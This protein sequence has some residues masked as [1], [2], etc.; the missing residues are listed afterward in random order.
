MMTEAHR[1]IP[2]S[3]AK[4]RWSEVLDAVERG[5]T[6]VVTRHGEP[7]A[8]I[9]PAR[10]TRERLHAMLDDWEKRRRN[11]PKATVDEIQSW[12]DEGRR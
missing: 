5:E 7:I 1:R 4:A 12:I 6:I 3:E 11:M 8:Q 9:E 10:P 2:A